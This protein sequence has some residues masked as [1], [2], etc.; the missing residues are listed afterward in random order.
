MEKVEVWKTEDGQ[1]F[2]FYSE[3]KEH[4]TKQRVR[5]NLDSLF[6]SCDVARS[7]SD[8]V[9]EVMVENRHAFVEALG[10]V[11]WADPNISPEE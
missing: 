9:L 3:A 10:G 1:M 11:F 7:Y 2:G 6:A 8:H 5:R 4:E